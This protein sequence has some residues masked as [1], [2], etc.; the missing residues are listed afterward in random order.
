M[1]KF[2]DK[3]ELFKL[4]GIKNKPFALFYKPSMM[5]RFSSISGEELSL[6]HLNIILRHVDKSVTVN[7]IGCGRG[8]FGL[9]LAKRK[10]CKVW[11]CDGSERRTGIV[12]ILSKISDLDVTCEKLLLDEQNVYVVPETDVTLFLSVYH[13]IYINQ[14]E[15]T[16]NKILRILWEKTKRTMIFAMA[17]SREYSYPKYVEGMKYFGLEKEEI[18]GNI[19]KLLKSLSKSKVSIIGQCD[20]FNTISPRYFFKVEK[21]QKD[22]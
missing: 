5:V 22:N 16:A 19:T 14:G 21:L 7:D 8:F 2:K 18:K 15:K 10:E 20:Y 1:V 9:E 3:Y 11:A 13:Q 17:D 4:E 6:K 12:K